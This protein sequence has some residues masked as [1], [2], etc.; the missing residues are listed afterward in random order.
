MQ[1]GSLWRLGNSKILVD[2]DNIFLL[3]TIRRNVE[4][5]EHRNKLVIDINEDSIV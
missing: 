4:V 3:L 1:E 2:G 5:R